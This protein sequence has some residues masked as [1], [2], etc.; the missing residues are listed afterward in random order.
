[1]PVYGRDEEM[2]VIETL[3]YCRA[4]HYIFPAATLP[5]RYP[6]CGKLYAEPI[7]PSGRQMKRRWQNIDRYRESLLKKIKFRKL[8]DIALHSGYNTSVGI[9]HIFRRK[10]NYPCNCQKN[11]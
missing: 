10:V 4:C 11:F 3:Y 6:D 8:L 9:A 1:M 5:D 2:N 7:Q